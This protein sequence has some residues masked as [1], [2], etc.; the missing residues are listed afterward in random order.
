MEVRIGRKGYKIRTKTELEVV[1]REIDTGGGERVPP[2]MFH[3]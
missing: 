3:R 2:R 1:L